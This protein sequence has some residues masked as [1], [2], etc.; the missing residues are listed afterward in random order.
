[1]SSIGV[2]GHVGGLRLFGSSCVPTRLS[3]ALPDVRPIAESSPRLG[4]GR[5]QRIHRLERRISG[6]LATRTP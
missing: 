3:S 6:T 4:Q 2:I 1:M 5:L